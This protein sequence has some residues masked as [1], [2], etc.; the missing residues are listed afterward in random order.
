[1]LGSVS[2]ARLIR[3]VVVLLVDAASLLLLSAIL[4]NF[5]LDD[6][7]AG[8]AAAIVVGAMNAVVWPLLARFTLPLSVLTLGIGTLILNGALVAFAIDL[9]P[10]ASIDDFWTGVVVALGITL[11]TTLVARSE[12]RRV[13]KEC[14]S[15]WSPYH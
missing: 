3:A 8:F 9:V 10:G 6:A 11:I 4:P 5:N 7:G 14:R 2:R 1:M 12:E 15:R 13:G